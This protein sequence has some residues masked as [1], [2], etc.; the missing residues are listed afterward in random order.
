VG[1]MN[2]ERNLEE[3]LFQLQRLEKEGK[4]T[5]GLQD[6]VWERIKEEIEER[7]DREKQGFPEPRREKH[8]ERK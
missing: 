7:I 6:R 5:Q 4:N 3:F 8:M 1:K 2:P